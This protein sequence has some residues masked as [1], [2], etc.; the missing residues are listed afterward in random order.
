MK[1]ARM[2]TMLSLRDAGVVGA[3][4]TPQVFVHVEDERLVA[5]QLVAAAWLEFMCDLPV[6]V[7]KF[8]GPRS[9]RAVLAVIDV[10]ALRLVLNLGRVFLSSVWTGRCRS[11][12]Y[13]TGALFFSFFSAQ[14]DKGWGW[15]RLLRFFIVGFDYEERLDGID[16]LD[17]IIRIL[18][19]V[20]LSDASV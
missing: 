10:R 13:V 5:V 4:Q 12:S 19:V 9:L 16:Y 2:A 20:Y 18:V 7:Q 14:H 3:L 15:W 1:S 11:A 8:D 6:R 17:V